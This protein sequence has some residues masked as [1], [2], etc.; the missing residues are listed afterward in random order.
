MED[1]ETPNNGNIVVMPDEEEDESRRYP[2]LKYEDMVINRRKYRVPE[3]IIKLDFW[4]KIQRSKHRDGQDRDDV[5]LARQSWRGQADTP[6]SSQ[7]QMSMLPTSSWDSPRLQHSRRAPQCLQ[8]PTNRPLPQQRSLRLLL[9]RWRSTALSH[10]QPAPKPIQRPS[11]TPSMIPS[12]RRS[13][14]SLPS[15]R[16]SSPTDPVGP[17]VVHLCIVHT[18]VV[19]IR[20]AFLP[21]PSLHV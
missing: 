1:A 21:G 14:S 11:E 18:A 13:A 9:R 4:S 8:Q 20:H 7:T 3:K 19:C 15:S 10:K 6:G 12:N 2:P 5:S 17:I 16:A